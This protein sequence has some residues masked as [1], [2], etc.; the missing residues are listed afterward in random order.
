MN[1]NVVPYDSG[2]PPASR[3]TLQF[4]SNITD[5]PFLSYFDNNTDA[6]QPDDVNTWPPALILDFFYGCAALKEWGPKDFTTFVKK[7]N[8]DYYS[9]TE[10]SKGKHGDKK[11]GPSKQVI[12]R[13]ARYEA[14]QEKRDGKRKCDDQE[15]CDENTMSE[16][17]D[18]VMGLWMRH[19][20]KTQPEQDIT[21]IPKD[22][23]SRSEM[24]QAWLTS[25]R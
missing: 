3:L 15:E 18:L 13:P 7:H 2:P 14:R 5:R 4:I 20:K 9:H 25:V 11:E 21:H 22:D 16:T 17:M 23:H 24:V 10:K 19:V 6:R 1:A 8:H 12:G